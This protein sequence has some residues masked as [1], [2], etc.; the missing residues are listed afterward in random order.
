LPE[1]HE[2]KAEKLATMLFPLNNKLAD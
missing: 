1:R 2:G